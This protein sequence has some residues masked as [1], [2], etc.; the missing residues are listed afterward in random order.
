[1]EFYVQRLA[2][3]SA[4][5]LGLIAAP[6]VALQMVEGNL[7][8]L[9]VIAG[10]GLLLFY[11]G[12]GS[13]YTFHILSFLVL[14]S[15]SF[16]FGFRVS[17]TEQFIALTTI[18]FCITWWRHYQIPARPGLISSGPIRFATWM[19]V[20]WTVFVLFHF[21]LHVTAYKYEGFKNILKSYVAL[22][23]PYALL[24]YF[25][26]RPNV[27]KIPKNY[28]KFFAF[29]VLV[30]TLLSLSARAYQT[31]IGGATYYSLN[32]EDPGL[33][34]PLFIPGI[35]YLEN[36]YAL[37]A[38]GVLC[39]SWGVCIL[40]SGYKGF[41]NFFWRCISLAM[42]SLGIAGSLFSGGRATIVISIV[43]SLVI[44]VLRK[45]HGLILAAVCAATLLIA[46][47]NV[48]SD[49]VNNQAPTQVSRTLQWVLIEKNPRVL[50]GIEDSS[51]WRMELAK[52]AIKEWMYEP[53]TIALGWGFR[54][55]SE[56]DIATADIAASG[57]LVSV[58]EDFA[59]Y[60]CIKRV[61]T[62]NLL[63][64]LLVAFGIV[65][66]VIY[67]VLIISLMI[68]TFH[69]YFKLPKNSIHKDFALQAAA[70]VWVNGTLGNVAG[71]FLPIDVFLYLSIL[72]SAIY[73][74]GI[75][76]SSRN[77][78]TKVEMVS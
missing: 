39:V 36:I 1:M 75:G 63:T 22:S 16:D 49:W 8:P 7:L 45:K 55:I 70:A 78:R 47:A 64:D 28:A 40:T 6:F 31:F 12:G 73:Q 41:H 62:H 17:P 42:I 60:I 48:F 53:K 66:A 72:I 33:A 65:G 59:H 21:I 61:A 13:N 35:R 71:S 38:L 74:L 29:A 57:N 56:S 32:P 25:I 69:L 9:T 54:G 52:K 5:A 37:R 68:L 24:L 77:A 50:A 15:A 2:I 26:A 11:L 46:L 43:L 76:D 27:L 18:L 44:L 10:A 34:L 23:F 51:R 3:F 20:V 30:A 58:D 14:L 4:F 67:Y 19:L